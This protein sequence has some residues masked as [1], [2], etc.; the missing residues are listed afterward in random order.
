[1]VARRRKSVPEGSNEISLSILLAQAVVVVYS[2]R[3]IYPPLA[4]PP[5][6]Y[7]CFK[8]RLAFSQ[9]SFFMLASNSSLRQNFELDPAYR[10]GFHDTTCPCQVV[11]SRWMMPENQRRCRGYVRSKLTIEKTIYLPNRIPRNTK[12]ARAIGTITSSVR[13]SA[14]RLNGLTL[15]YISALI[16]K[17]TV[18]FSSDQ[19]PSRAAQIMDRSGGNP[20]FARALVEAIVSDYAEKLP[21]NIHHQVGLYLENLDAAEYG[22]ICHAAVLGSRHEIHRLTEVVRPVSDVDVMRADVPGCSR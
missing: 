18:D 19:I 15:T 11:A 10:V 21:E 8:D 16:S 9:S 5:I 3:C 17:A 4:E 1:M 7:T 2:R 13:S 12:L 6:Q 14:V 22:I 20:L